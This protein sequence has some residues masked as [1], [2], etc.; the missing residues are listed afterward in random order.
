[1][2]SLTDALRQALAA[3]FKIAK[4]WRHVIVH[5]NVAVGSLGAFRT[6]PPLYASPPPALPGDVFSNYCY[7]LPLPTYVLDGRF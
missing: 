7:V 5:E 6:C 3:R 1:M 2:L 4:N